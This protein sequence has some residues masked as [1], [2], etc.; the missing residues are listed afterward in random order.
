MAFTLECGN[1]EES[2]IE[3]S[4]KLDS[5]SLTVYYDDGGKKTEWFS[6][7]AGEKIEPKVK[8]FK[9]GKVYFVVETTEK[10]EEGKL[11]FD[12]VN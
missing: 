1:S 10:C 2:G 6:L 8:R 3:Y 12:V 9:E 11:D 4:G 5:G 7:K